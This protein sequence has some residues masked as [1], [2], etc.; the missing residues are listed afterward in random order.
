[1]GLGQFTVVALWPAAEAQVT[2]SEVLYQDGRYQPEAEFRYTVNGT[3]YVAKT[4]LATSTSAYPHAKGLADQCS[5]GTRQ[6]IRYDPRH[7]EE[8]FANA[9]YTLN[10][11]R[12]PIL[13][14]EMGVI[15]AFLTWRLVFRTPTRAK[16]LSAA[17][18]WMIAAGILAA[19][20]ILFLA[21]GIWQ[22]YTDY[23]VMKTWPAADAQV[24]GNRVRH[25]RKYSS[26]YNAS[27][28]YQVIVEF[29]YT[30]AGKEF[31]SPSSEEFS[32]P[33]EA[34]RERTLYA[35]GSR[36]QIRYNPGD[37]NDIRFH[38]SAADFSLLRECV[39]PGMGL[40]FAGIGGGVL[41]L[42]R[43]KGNKAA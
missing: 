12:R 17:H 8:I 23:Q 27:D 13:V 1:M 42:L 40:L 38:V 18:T 41:Y 34:D 19:L 33:V 28:A 32:S 36:Q 3:E 6:T 10:F 39:F 5:P 35:V 14:L 31:V 25:Y 16:K 20:G 4:V 30:A 43:R 29:R 37:A 11:F 2:K 26:K 22:V 9:G 7:P 24:T 15:I 21:A